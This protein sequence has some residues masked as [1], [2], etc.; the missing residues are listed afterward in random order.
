MN[1]S[2]LILCGGIDE[3]INRQESE[4]IGL[5]IDKRATMLTENK[6]CFFRWCFHMK[7]KIQSLMI[8]HDMLW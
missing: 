8:M 6:Y 5:I 2:C 3:Y 7:I 4:G 1:K